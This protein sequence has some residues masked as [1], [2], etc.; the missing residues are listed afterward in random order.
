MHKLPVHAP[1]SAEA[2]DFSSSPRPGLPDPENCYRSC[3]YRS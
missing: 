2:P 3:R 1:G